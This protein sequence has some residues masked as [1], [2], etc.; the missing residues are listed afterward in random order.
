VSKSRLQRKYDVQSGIQSFQVSWISKASAAQRAGRAGRTGPG[1]CY[2]LYSSALF[3]NYFDEFAQPEI[4]RI[5][6]EGVVLQMKAMNIDA[7]VNFPFPT[8]PDRT[9]LKHA[10]TILG[11]LGALDGAMQGS[12]V[13]DLGRTMALFPVAPRFSKMLVSARQHGC[14]P[15]IV[16]IVATLSVGDPFLRAE[17]LADADDTSD[18]ECLLSP[19]TVPEISQIRGSKIKE[20]EVAKTRRRAFFTSQQACI[21]GRVHVYVC[22]L[23]RS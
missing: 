17:T 3:E 2:R 8:P 13:T 11:H 12:H 4:L 16:A 10:E 19:D 14:L 22:L 1:H 21:V 7:V 9:S 23:N 6:I 15:Y 5:P 20:K 18:D